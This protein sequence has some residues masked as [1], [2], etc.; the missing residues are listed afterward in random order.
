M[1]L[2]RDLSG[3]N[4]AS[5]LAR[6]GYVVTRRTGSDLRP[7]TQSRGKHPITIPAQPMR[8]GIPCDVAAH[9]PKEKS[10]LAH[11]LFGDA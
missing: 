6:F 10:E 7:T 4:L 8:C 1:K 2:P 3:K 9:L 11:E 5:M